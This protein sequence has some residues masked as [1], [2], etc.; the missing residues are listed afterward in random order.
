MIA[1]TLRGREHD[2]HGQTNRAPKPQLIF[3]EVS[4]NK[5]GYLFILPVFLIFSITTIV[6]IF[7]TIYVSFFRW[8]PQSN[9]RFIGLQNYIQLF[10]DRLFIESFGRTLLVAATATPVAM[11]LGLIAALLVDSLVGWVKYIT[12]VGIFTPAVASLLVIGVIWRSLLSPGGIVMSALSFVGIN[13]VPWLSDPTLAMLGLIIMTVWA[14]V[15]FNMIFY[16]A[17]LQGI[18]P[19]LQEA[20]TVDGATEWRRF[21]SITLP[22]LRRTTIFLFVINGLANMKLF[23]QVMG[24][25][26]GG[27]M[28]ATLTSMVY[29]YR[30]AFTQSRYDYGAAAGVLFS[31]AIFGLVLLQVR[32]LKNQ[33][34]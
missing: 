1:D 2:P 4:E 25:T 5:S 26:K 29:I 17:G 20:A 8:S 3:G 14:S 9:L 28:D 18:P 19:E 27:P 32:S 6:P 33:V 7:W 23:D 21:R 12:V 30:A 16:L 11:A 24:L 10:G 15:G 34:E 31:L 13:T 22:L